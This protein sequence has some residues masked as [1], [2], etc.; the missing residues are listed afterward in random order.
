MREST[1]RAE[2]DQSMAPAG[3]AGA[4]GMP[5][6][7]PL[8]VDDLRG[9]RGASP[10]R[11]LAL[12][13]QAGNQYVTRLLGVARHRGDRSLARA[14]KDVPDYLAAIDT[15]NKMDKELRDYLTGSLTALHDRLVTKR[16]IE[17]LVGGWTDPEMDVLGNAKEAVEHILKFQAVYDIQEDA[18]KAELAARYHSYL[19]D[20]NPDE[21]M[22]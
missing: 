6:T 21:D 2:L 13:R 22:V 16:L 18:A 12:Q 10:A 3:P 20:L 5:A 14:K 11:L 4:L 15:D 8:G 9:R 17:V 19:K 7:P 1:D